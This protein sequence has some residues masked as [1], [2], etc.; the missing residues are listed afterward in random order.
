MLAVCAKF[1]VILVLVDYLIFAGLFFNYFDCCCV[2][3]LVLFYG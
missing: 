1:G 2:T 3:S